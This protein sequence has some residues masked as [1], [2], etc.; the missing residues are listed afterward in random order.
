M[1]AVGSIQYY[2]KNIISDIVI[3]SDV[4]N[5]GFLSSLIIRFTIIS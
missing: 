1:C 5:N 4:N 3:T 2:I